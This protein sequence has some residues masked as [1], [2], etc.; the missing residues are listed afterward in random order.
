MLAIAPRASSRS[1]RR[2]G[3]AWRRGSARRGSRAGSRCMIAMISAV[4]SGS[5]A[6]VQQRLDRLGLRAARQLRGEVGD[7]GL[8]D[9]DRVVAGDRQRPLAAGQLVARRRVAALLGRS[10][11][12]VVERAGGARGRAARSRCR[13][14]ACPR[15]RAS[16][17]SAR[18]RR[19]RARRRAPPRP[20]APGRRAGRRASPAR[21][22]RAAAAPRRRARSA[23]WRR[24][25]GRR[26][27][28]RTSARTGSGRSASRSARCRPGAPSASLASS[29]GSS[30]S[31]II[32]SRQ[33][34]WSP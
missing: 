26:A 13:R 21:A 4:A 20:A 16:R 18:A 11:E 27:P 7:R 9:L 25:R 23:A 30:V 3:S 22:G 15:R 19:G 2:P 12:L 33:R 6:H 29:P 31:T 8:V 24:P 5:V 34:S 28:T 14:A 10:A 1:R 17:S 32:V